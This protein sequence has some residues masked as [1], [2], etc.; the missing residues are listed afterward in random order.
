LPDRVSLRTAIEEYAVLTVSHFRR[1]PAA[2]SF[3]GGKQAQSGCDL[4]F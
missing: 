3:V 2:M 4:G 1:N